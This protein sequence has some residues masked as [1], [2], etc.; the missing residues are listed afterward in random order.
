MA[1]EAV[2]LELNEHMDA[3]QMTVAAGTS[4]SKGTLL[5]LSS[6]NTVVASDGVN[7]YGGVAAADKDGTDSSTTLGVYTPGQGNKFDMKCA[8]ANVTLGA[9]VVLSGTNLIRDAVNT[10]VEEGKVVGKAMEGGSGGDVIV[11][12]S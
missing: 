4:I 8:S 1:N 7:V 3:Y 5:K 11:I 12:L 6:A 10:E 9:L 2:I